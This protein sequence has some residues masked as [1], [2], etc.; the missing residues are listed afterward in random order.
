MTS[1]FEFIK[2]KNEFL[3]FFFK[4]KKTKTIKYSG[5]TKNRSSLITHHSSFVNIE[6]ILFFY[7]YKKSKPIKVTKGTKIYAVRV[8]SRK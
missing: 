4:E 3:V 6:I 7:K 1:G 2:E 8:Q 5:E